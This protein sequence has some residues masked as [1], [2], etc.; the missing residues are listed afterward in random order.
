MLI[1]SLSHVQLWLA[2]GVSGG[3]GASA[4][5][6]ATEGPRHVPGAVPQ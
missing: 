3:R 6:A 4:V 1:Q 5:L 2:T